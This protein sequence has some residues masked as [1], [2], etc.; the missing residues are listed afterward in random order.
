MTQPSHSGFGASDGAQPATERAD[1]TASAHLDPTVPGAPAPQANPQYDPTLAGGPNPMGQPPLGQA[2]LSQYPPQPGQQF[3]GQQFEGQQFQGQ[4][5]GQPYPG[6]QYGAP[7]QPP[8]YYPPQRGP[9]PSGGRPGIWIGLVLAVVIALVAGVLIY[10]LNKDDDD[11]ADSASS[12]PTPSAAGQAPVGSATAGAPATGTPRMEFLIG[13][14]LT[15]PESRPKVVVTVIEDYQCPACKAFGERFNATLGQIA[16]TPNAAVEYIPIAML[17]RA[18]TTNYS[19]RAW[20]ASICVA[21]AD[22]ESYFDWMVF[23]QVLF[24]MQPDE[25]GAGLTNEDLAQMAESSGAKD[26]RD[27]ILNETYRSFAGPQTNQVMAQPGFRG[28]PTVRINGEDV[29]LSTPEALK[30]E[31]DAKL[32]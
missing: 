5:Y 30:A 8:G 20:N 21:N 9:A 4:P 7:V 24:S 28:T 29:T 16:A 1:A 22:S 31:V 6:S 10:V 26:A 23:Q 2:P 12:T 27:C 17:D 3:P 15:A 11:P 32:R 13:M 25:G 14:G 18:S 19:S